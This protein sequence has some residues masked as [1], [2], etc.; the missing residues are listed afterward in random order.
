MCNLV[1]IVLPQ[2]TVSS[3]YLAFVVLPNSAENRG[4]TVFGKDQFNAFC[5]SEITYDYSNWRLPPH[6]YYVCSDME[7]IGRK[8]E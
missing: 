3:I 1:L 6:C 2:F 4:K 5:E 8:I 7:K